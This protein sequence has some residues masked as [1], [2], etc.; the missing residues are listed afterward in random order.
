MMFRL[1]GG[2]SDIKCPHCEKSYDVDWDTE[3]GDPLV[4]EHEADCPECEKEFHFS[5][6]HKYSSW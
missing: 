3:Y 6:Y 1:E 5:V 4:G 2:G